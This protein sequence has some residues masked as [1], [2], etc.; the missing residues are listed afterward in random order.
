MRH[1]AKLEIMV[2]ERS[3]GQGV[4]RRLMSAAMEWAVAHPTITKVGLS[5]FSENVRATKLYREFGFVEE[6]HRVREY[7]LEDGSYRDD[8]LMYRWVGDT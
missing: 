8:V 4:G 5:V 1:C 2:A 6:G 7:R 3:R